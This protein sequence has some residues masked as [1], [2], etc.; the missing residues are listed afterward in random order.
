MEARSLYEISEDV[1]Q[2]NTYQKQK[3]P[4][5]KKKNLL[6][7]AVAGPSPSMQL[8]VF[9]PRAGAFGAGAILELCAQLAW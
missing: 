8:L 3:Q 6:I 5:L 2:L 9:W 7:P 4:L 1:A